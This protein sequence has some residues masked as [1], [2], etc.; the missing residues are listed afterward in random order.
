MEG[1]TV[2]LNVPNC[3]DTDPEL[4]VRLVRKACETVSDKLIE[5]AN[6]KQQDLL[7]ELKH[8]QANRV[9]SLLAKYI[10]WTLCI[11]NPT[12]PSLD[13]AFLS[14]L[15]SFVPPTDREEEEHVEQHKGIWQW[16]FHFLVLLVAGILY[17]AI[18][19]PF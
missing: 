3:Q 14:A 6:L 2:T 18:N 12:L 19:W 8:Q 11:E 13:I 15:A 16:R 17:L 9:A 5:T 10:I 4:Y 1:A 7:D